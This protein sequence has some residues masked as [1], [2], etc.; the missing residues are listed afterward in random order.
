MPVTESRNARS[1]LMR[2]QA[3]AY[4]QSNPTSIHRDMFFGLGQVTAPSNF[5]TMPPWMSPVA[6]TPRRQ[7]FLYEP[8]QR[9]PWYPGD[10]QPMRSAIE[11]QKAH[12]TLEQQASQSANNEETNQVAVKEA[13]QSPITSGFHPDLNIEITSY[14]FTN[15]KK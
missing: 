4:S 14:H 11:Q 8:F 12:L 13:I 5:E 15:P 10:I 6:A 2:V 3:Q 1:E 9:Q 7:G